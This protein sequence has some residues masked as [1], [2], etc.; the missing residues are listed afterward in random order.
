MQGRRRPAEAA[1]ATYRSLTT[2]LT[3]DVVALEVK[4]SQAR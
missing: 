3:G 1:G 4:P 2:Q